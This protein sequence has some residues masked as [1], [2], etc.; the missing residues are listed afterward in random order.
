MLKELRNLQK[1]EVDT[2]GVME[3]YLRRKSYFENYEEF[4]KKVKELAKKFFGQNFSRVIVF[5][6]VVKGEFSVGL[7]D[8]DIAILT[9]KHSY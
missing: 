9:K 4:A 5:G 7:S 1:A 6:S 8:I 3:V 2:M